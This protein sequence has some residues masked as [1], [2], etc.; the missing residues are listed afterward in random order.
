[1]RFW[2]RQGEARRNT[3]WLLL[4]FALCVLAV[5]A[6]VHLGLALAWLL[7]AWMLP[8]QWAYPAGFT[9]VNVGVTLVLVLGGWWLETDSLRGGGQRLARRVGAR[10]ARP[11]SSLAEQQLCNIVQEMCIAA[12]MQAPQVMVLARTEAI[13]AFAA[14]WDGDDAKDAVLAVTQGALEHLTREEMQGLVAHELSHLHEG[15]TRMNMQLGGMVFGLELVYNYGDTLRE[16]GGPFWWFGSAIMAAGFV[17]WLS[18]HL[19]KA[20]VSR[21]REFLADA[22]AVQWTR[23]RDGLGGVLRKVMTQ[24][25]EERRHYGSSGD[26][27]SHVGLNHP[28]VQHMLLVDAPGGSHLQAWLESHP[29]LGDRVRR[30]YGRGMGPLPLRSGMQPSGVQ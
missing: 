20:A 9:A 27:R 19:L 14:G 12:H 3:R 25:Q 26:A 5:V 2:H 16:R 6:A 7:A 22:R 1:M 28:A 10:E 8:G 15:D 17:G 24:R 21:Q 30:I 23:S 11:G 18:G 29:P 13:N 4:A